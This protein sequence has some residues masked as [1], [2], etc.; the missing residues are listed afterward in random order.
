MEESH[1]PMLAAIMTIMIYHRHSD[2][3][4]F[5]RDSSAAA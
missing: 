5:Y 4:A 2:G 1:A 3:S